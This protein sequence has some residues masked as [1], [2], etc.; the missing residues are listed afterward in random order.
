MQE[1]ARKTIESYPD[2]RARQLAEFVLQVLHSESRHLKVLSLRHDALARI[3]NGERDPRGIA[4]SALRQE[5][6]TGG[7]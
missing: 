1:L 4:L 2:A 7:K 6:K 5:E 3:V